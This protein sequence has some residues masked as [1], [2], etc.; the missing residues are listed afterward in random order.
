MTGLVGSQT[1]GVL[2]AE[3]SSR[4]GAGGRDRRASAADAAPIAHEGDGAA[5]DGAVQGQLG[6]GAEAG[7]NLI[8]GD[9]ESSEREAVGRELVEE[10]G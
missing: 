5:V 9:G 8:G 10:D 6:L 4:L 3:T 7:D 1:P 2:E